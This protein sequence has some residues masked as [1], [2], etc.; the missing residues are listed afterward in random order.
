MNRPTKTQ[1]PSFWSALDPR[2]VK[3]QIM[4]AEDRSSG[5]NGN[6]SNIPT[7]IE[8]HRKEPTTRVVDN[9][10]EDG[11]I[12]DLIVDNATLRHD[13]TIKQLPPRLKNGPQTTDDKSSS[14]SSHD[15]SL[16][17]DDDNM[18]SRHHRRRQNRKRRGIR[19]MVLTGVLL[20]LSIL[21]IIGELFV[22]CERCC[23]REIFINLT[24]NYY[25]APPDFSLL[26]LFQRY[27]YKDKVVVEM[28][29]SRHPSTMSQTTK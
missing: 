7:I 19:F 9:S 20:L 12:G 18:S 1:Q 3:K 16:K 2:C 11:F 23:K 10:E 29:T 13:D 15:H 14:S 17:S 25:C 28:I 21:A 4:D 27:I 6:N 26:K 8:F 5:D 24:P 22:C